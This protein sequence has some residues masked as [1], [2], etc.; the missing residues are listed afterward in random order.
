[1]TIPVPIY[2]RATDPLSEAG[3]A[4]HLRWQP[5][6]QLVDSGAVDGD[7]VAIVAVTALDD[8]SLA[9]LRSVNANGCQRIVL[10]V[11]ELDDAGLLSAIEHGVCWVEHRSEATPE[12]LARLAIKASAGQAA[13][14]PDVI[15]RLLKQVTRIKHKVLE[16]MGLTFSGMSPREIA[17]LKLVAEGLDTHEIAKDLCYSERTIKNILHDVNNRYHLKNR[18]HAVAYALR[19]GLI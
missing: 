19:E 2:V 15:G 18:P 5:D 8:Q 17:V 12:R 13:L 1:M 10:V 7:V 11:E 16:P 14:P 9:L 3:L 6:V 4:A